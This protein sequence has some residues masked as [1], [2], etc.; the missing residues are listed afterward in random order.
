[1]T[2]NLA[3]DDKD[4]LALS[5]RD[6]DRI[7]KTFSIFS[8]NQTQNL[9]DRRHHKSTSSLLSEEKLKCPYKPQ[10]SKR[11]ERITSELT[12]RLRQNKIPHHEVLLFKG[13]ELD[14]RKE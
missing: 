8:L 1:M 11:S 9:L 5:Q 13:R 7:H 14:I 12:K 4:R 6:I 10:I 2:F 3:F